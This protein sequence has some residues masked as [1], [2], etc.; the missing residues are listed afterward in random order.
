MQTARRRPLRLKAAVA[1]AIIGFAFLAAAGL[2]YR[3]QAATD[4]GLA[5]H[6]ITTT[7]IIST[8]FHGQMTL[9]PTTGSSPVYTLYAIAAFTAA[10]RPAHTR[11]TL[12]DCSGAC[13]DY[14]D[15]Q[16]LMITYD[17]RNPAIAVVGQP[18]APP[19]HLNYAVLLFAVIGL[20]FLSAARRVLGCDP[21]RDHDGPGRRSCPGPSS[22]CDPSRDHDGTMV[23]PQARTGTGR[24]WR[25]C[26]AAVQ[27]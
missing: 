24:R 22:S 4:N 13:G 17:S 7:A 26:F 3:S 19:L 6:G 2:G 20:L 27:R 15:G 21:S 10:G 8:V 25:G 11:V 18:A 9:G 1:P 23:K 14:R 12:E 16:Q 5:D